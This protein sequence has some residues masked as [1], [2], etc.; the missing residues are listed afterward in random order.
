[1]HVPHCYKRRIPK[2]KWE[3]NFRSTIIAIGCRGACVCVA[4][5][6]CVSNGWICCD[7]PALKHTC[8]RAQ[9][10][11][12]TRFVEFKSL[13]DFFFHVSVQDTCLTNS[14]DCE[15]EWQIHL[16]SL[17]WK[18]EQLAKNNSVCWMATISKLAKIVS[19][20]M[21]QYFHLS[22]WNI[23]PYLTMQL[24]RQCFYSFAKAGWLFPPQWH[25]IWPK[26]NDQYGDQ[27]ILVLSAGTQTVKLSKGPRDSDGHGIF[28]IKSVF[29]HS[30]N[31]GKIHFLV[32]YTRLFYLPTDVHFNALRHRHFKADMS[33]N[34]NKVCSLSLI[35]SYILLF[36]CL[37]N[38]HWA[39]LCLW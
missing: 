3:T 2:Y 8:C 32:S 37:A 26:C 34:W 17:A 7:A 21:L 30:T 25:Y 31:P 4:Q 28:S 20:K 9:T 35:F 39:D 6:S 19:D 15:T 14:V 11:A 33:L 18:L 10:K 24:W 27:S 1:M 13:W 16:C 22:A 36:P 5:L 29:Y 12:T 38:G 23:A